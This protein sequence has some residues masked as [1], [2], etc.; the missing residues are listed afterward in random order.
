MNIALWT[1]RARQAQSRLRRKPRRVRQTFIVF[2]RDLD[3]L[4]RKLGRRLARQ[5]IVED[6]HIM[7]IDECRAC[8]CGKIRGA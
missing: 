1:E 6:A 2:K 7:D 4:K 3:T 5:L 8:V